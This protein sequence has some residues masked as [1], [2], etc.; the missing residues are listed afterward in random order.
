MPKDATHAPR[1][2]IYSNASES[3]LDQLSELQTSFDNLARKVKEIEWQVTVHNA[4]PTVSRS[5]LLESKDAIAQMVGALDKLQYNG[6]DGVITAQLKSGK[7]RVRDQRKALNRHCEALRTSMMSLHQQL[8]VHVSTNATS[9]SELSNIHDIEESSQDKSMQDPILTPMAQPTEEDH[10]VVDFQEERQ[11]LCCVK[12]GQTR[13]L[14]QQSATAVY[15]PRML[16]VGP[17]AGC[18]LITYTIILAPIFVYIFSDGLASWIS[19]VLALSIVLTFVAFSMVACSDPGVIKH[20]YVSTTG[21]EAGI[22]CA[23]CQ[24]RRPAEAIHCYEC[25]VCIDGMDHHCPWTGKCIGKQTIMWFYLFLWM[26]C[27]HL[28][29]SIGTV[30]YYAI[31]RPSSG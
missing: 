18:M 14:C 28:A 13:Y 7:E 8:T 21:E 27:I 9:V 5:D 30:V 11:A 3:A 23:H 17:N 12:F 10:T 19:V 4:T 16:H 26:I 2:R 20:H 29:L 25:G 1:Q 15:F 6:I 31:S 22:L 24:I